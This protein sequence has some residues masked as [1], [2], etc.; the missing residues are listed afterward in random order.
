MV[1]WFPSHSFDSLILFSLSLFHKPH[2]VGGGGHQKSED[3][4]A[5]SAMTELCGVLQISDLLSGVGK[6]KKIFGN[7]KT[8][9]YSLKGEVSNW[10]YGEKNLIGDVVSASPPPQEEKCL[11]RKKERHLGRVPNS[12]G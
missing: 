12:E 6:D 10:A 5:F 4:L 2:L 7:L 8:K 1:Y 3:R 11:G 9:E